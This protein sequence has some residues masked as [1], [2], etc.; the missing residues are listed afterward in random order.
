MNPD[1]S[2]DIK[3]REAQL[4]LEQTKLDQKRLEL[5]Q[6]K[7]ESGLTEPNKTKI[8]PKWS[9]NST[10]LAIFLTLFAPVGLILLWKYPR[11][12]ILFKILMSLYSLFLFS[13]VLDFF[14]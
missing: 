10:V 3:E 4:K 12:G 13:I 14:V 6:M 7:I 5:E 9:E 8:Q 11:G 2:N 1:N